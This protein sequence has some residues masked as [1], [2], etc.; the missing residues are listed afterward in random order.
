[1]D[2]L[3]DDIANRQAASKNSQTSI[4]DSAEMRECTFSPKMSGRRKDQGPLSFDKFLSRM[5][6]DLDSRAEKEQER[7]SMLKK[8]L[9]FKKEGHGA[10]VQ[11]IELNSMWDLHKRE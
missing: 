3:A 4:R 6:Q 8:K 9:K 5:H 1:M 2:R 7:Q 10:N 11:Y